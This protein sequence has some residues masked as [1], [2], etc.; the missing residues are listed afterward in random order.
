MPHALV[1][2]SL[3]KT[4]F[5]KLKIEPF[6]RKKGHRHPAVFFDLT[7]LINRAQMLDVRSHNEAVEKK[8]KKLKERNPF[9][10]FGKRT[11]Q[12]RKLP[13]KR[14]THF[15]RNANFPYRPKKRL[16]DRRSKERSRS[17]SFGPLTMP[18]M[19]SYYNDM[20][21]FTPIGVQNEVPQWLSELVA[22][23]AKNKTTE[24]Q[25]KS[26]RKSKETESKTRGSVTKKEKKKI[27]ESKRTE[28]KKGAPLNSSTK[29]KKNNQENRRNT[30]RHLR[31]KKSM[32]LTQFQDPTKVKHK[33]HFF[34]IDLLAP[35]EGSKHT[36]HRYKS[37]PSNAISL[38]RLER[39]PNPFH[40]RLTLL[41]ADM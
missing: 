23:D 8:W 31:K 41:L 34:D 1:R 36:S 11:R 12:Q 5:Y 19:N 10:A 13:K 38:V 33:M 7:P 2:M 16:A 39:G 35:Y 14:D 6:H 30:T 17:L 37:Y 3:V 22:E 32:P 4:P 24:V 29:S 28:Q 27:Q 9:K 26:K 15:K 25:P 40:T 20:R 18:Y 21:G